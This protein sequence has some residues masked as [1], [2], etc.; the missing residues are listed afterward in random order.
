MCESVNVSLGKGK[1]AKIL[2][3]W[4]VLIFSSHPFSSDSDEMAT[5]YR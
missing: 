5:G 1:S 3:E 2:T 4:Q